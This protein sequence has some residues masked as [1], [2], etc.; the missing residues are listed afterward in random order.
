MMISPTFDIESFVASLSDKD[1]SEIIHI[2]DQEA[3]QAWRA[4]QKKKLDPE[5]DTALCESYQKKVIALINYLRYESRSCNITRKE[6]EMFESLRSCR[7][8]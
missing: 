7:S 4:G 8:H 2:A 3:L 1:V 5:P 6:C